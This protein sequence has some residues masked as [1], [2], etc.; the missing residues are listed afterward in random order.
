MITRLAEEVRWTDHLTI[1]LKDLCEGIFHC[2]LVLIST[3]CQTHCADTRGNSIDD[4]NESASPMPH[5]MQTPCQTK[6]HQ[7]YNAILPS[8]MQIDED[9]FRRHC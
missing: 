9:S 8:D 6:W 7:G 5:L 4:S 2:M 1:V 3:C